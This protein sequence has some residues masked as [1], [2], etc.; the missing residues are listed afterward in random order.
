MS[1]LFS[2]QM[3]VYGA[4]SIHNTCRQHIEI[5]SEG[6]I[7][8]KDSLQLHPSFRIQSNSMVKIAVA[9]SHFGLCHRWPDA[10]A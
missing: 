7:F 4:L 3:D 1:I 2:C 8:F 6:L 5:V 10:E 9:C